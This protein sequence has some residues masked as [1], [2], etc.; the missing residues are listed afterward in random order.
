MLARLVEIEC[1]VQ[2]QVPAG[3]RWDVMEVS[4]AGAPLTE[5]ET[6]TT[7]SWRPWRGL[8]ASR[9]RL[10]G[11]R[12]RPDLYQDGRCPISVALYFYWSNIH[13]NKVFQNKTYRKSSFQMTS[14]L[15]LTNTAIFWWWSINFLKQIFYLAISWFILLLS[16]NHCVLFREL[17]SFPKIHVYKNQ[18]YRHFYI[19]FVN[20]WIKYFL[21]K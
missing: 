14:T 7:M 20:I 10:P 21:F 2:Q 12:T 17:Q 9:L 16:V 13:Q 1:G 8:R 3:Q 4:W 5:E 19:V 6:G 11:D 18:S 15:I